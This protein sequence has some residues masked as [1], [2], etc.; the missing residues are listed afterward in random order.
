ALARDGDAAKEE[1]PAQAGGSVGQVRHSG[2][3]FRAVVMPGGMILVDRA[4]P[5][6]RQTA[7]AGRLDYRRRSP[8]AGAI[9]PL[10]YTFR[11]FPPGRSSVASCPHAPCMTVA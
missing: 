8:G 9:D 5:G 1:Q 4:L 10:R 7:A 3:G 2:L 6:P 11:A